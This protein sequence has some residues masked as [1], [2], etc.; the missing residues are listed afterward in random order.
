[1]GTPLE[2]GACS[3]PWQVPGAL[4]AHAQRMREDA[5]EL[6]HAHSSA[7]AGVPWVACARALEHAADNLDK[8]L[9]KLGM[10]AQ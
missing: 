9:N 1:M 7:A 8:T 10:A 3:A 2:L 6:Q 4:R 5:S